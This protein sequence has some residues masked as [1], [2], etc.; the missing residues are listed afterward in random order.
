MDVPREFEFIALLRRL[1]GDPAARN[2]LDDAAVIEFGGKQLVLTHDMIIEGVHFLSSDPPEDVAW[3]L[4]A[5]NLSDLAAK[6]ARPI[7]LLLGYGLTGHSFWDEAFVRGLGE[8]TAH[9]KAPLL[10]G[11]TVATPS[12][13]PRT[14][15]M[16]AIGEAGGQ[17]PSRSGAS[18]GDLLWVSGTIGDSGPGLAIAA[19]KIPGPAAL[20]A[21]YRRPTPRLEAGQALAPLASAMMDVSD[22]L[23]IDASRM[24]AASGLCIE[25]ELRNIPLS[26]DLL[27]MLGGDRQVRIDSATAGDDYELLFAAPPERTGEIQALSASLGLPLTALGRFSAGAGLALADRGEPIPLPSSLGYEHRPA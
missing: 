7:G 19:G 9:L 18:A 22:G 8:A 11:D 16:T 2:L 20:A 15:G 21:R 3:K 13:A 5:V 6:G 25:L 14:L 1:A 26:T 17:V 12:G 10:G 4:V 24:A 27:D 23:L